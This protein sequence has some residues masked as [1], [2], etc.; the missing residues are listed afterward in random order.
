MIKSLGMD[1][2][3]IHACPND[4]ILYWKDNATLSRCPTCGASRWKS[5]FLIKNTRVP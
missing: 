1:Y 5:E 3:T 4:C 2:K